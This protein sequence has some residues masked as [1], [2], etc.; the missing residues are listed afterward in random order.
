MT[1][2]F[3]NP[4]LLPKIGL[5]PLMN[6]L[7]QNIGYKNDELIDNKFRSILFQVPAPGTDPA[8]C[9]G[10]T[11]APGCFS[12]VQD[13]GAIDVQRGRDHGIPTYNT[14]RVAYGLAP[15]TSYTQIADDRTQH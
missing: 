7:A 9:I 6:G 13:L 14:L 4:S 12:D 11:V 15:V 3:G 10:E 5:G 2:A 8:S 1:S